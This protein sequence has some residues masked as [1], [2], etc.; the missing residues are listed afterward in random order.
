MK[1]RIVQGNI[2]NYTGSAIVNAANP[3]LLGGGGVDGAIHQAA[4]PELRDECA[5]FPVSNNVRCDVSEVRVT[6]AYNLGVAK[7]FHT[8]GPIFQRE[9]RL[10]PGEN[11]N[12]D[13]SPEVLLLKTYINCLVMTEGWGFPDVAFPAISCGV[14]GCPLELGASVAANACLSRKWDIEEV[15]FILFHEYEFKVFHDFFEALGLLA[16]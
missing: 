16:D 8:V 11:P 2:V 10:R 1:I 13:Q 7:V 3:S 15:T 4:G 12:Q 5:K 9:G 6:D 14:Y